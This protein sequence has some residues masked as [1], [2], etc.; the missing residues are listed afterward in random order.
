M[1][2][3][4][5]VIFFIFFVIGP[6]IKG[7]LESNKKRR[8][9]QQRQEMRKDKSLE[10]KKIEPVQPRPAPVFEYPAFDE[11]SITA[12]E[13]KDAENMQTHFKQDMREA[14]TKKT[15]YHEELKNVSISEADIDLEHIF[16]K[17]NLLG[18]IILKEVLEPP[19]G[20]LYRATSGCPY[21]RDCVRR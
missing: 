15:S 14:A 20:V 16:T 18:G 3:D 19:K 6:I 21:E 4:T 11:A 17:N 2:F 1:N 10:I 5:L 7:L 9:W 8:A 13:A 12:K